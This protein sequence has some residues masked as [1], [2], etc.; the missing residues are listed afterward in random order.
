MNKQ[1]P[2]ITIPYKSSWKFIDIV[3]ILSI[4]LMIAYAYLSYVD[5][6]EEIPVHFNHKGEADSYGSK[7]SI[8]LLPI[9]S[10]FLYLLL[11][12]V[13]KYPHT[14]NYAVKISE[15]N[16]AKQYEIALDMMAQLKLLIVIF[17]SYMTYRTIHIAINGHSGMGL[18][19]IWILPVVLTIVIIRSLYLSNVYK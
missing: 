18:L 10:I 17:F 16:A 11:T 8:W 15:N 3:C 7:G 14:F 1:Q 19:P 13:S 2:K 5:L 4:A 6:P 12:V 9:L